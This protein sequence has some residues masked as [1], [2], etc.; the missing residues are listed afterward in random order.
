LGAGVEPS[1]T[2]ARGVAGTVAPSGQQ[3]LT[4]SPWPTTSTRV[5]WSGVA[6]SIAQM[7]IWFLWAVA[8][9]LVVALL[10]G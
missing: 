6:L 4:G 7:S 5:S 1:S 9:L 3:P 8:R 10:A 2:R